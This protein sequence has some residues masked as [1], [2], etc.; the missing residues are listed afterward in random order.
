MADEKPKEE[1]SFDTR[2]I[3]RNLS[4]ESYLRATRQNLDALDNFDLVSVHDQRVLN[5]IET[6]ECRVYWTA[7][8]RQKELLDVFAKKVPLDAEAVV[9]YDITSTGAG[10]GK[11]PYA[12]FL[13]VQ[14]GIALVPRKKTEQ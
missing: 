1:P 14:S 5:Y 3:Y 11:Y 7:G 2:K 6:K 13:V 10:A 4:L 9:Q 8:N 12:G